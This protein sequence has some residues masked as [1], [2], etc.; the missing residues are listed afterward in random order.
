MRKTK[1]DRAARKNRAAAPQTSKGAPIYPILRP[2]ATALY[3]IGSTA[4]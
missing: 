2:K 1:K 3:R 4:W